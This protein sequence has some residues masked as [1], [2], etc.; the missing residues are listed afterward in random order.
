VTLPRLPLSLVVTIGLVALAGIML[1]RAVAGSRGELAVAEA[2]QEEGQ[3][4][5]AVEHYRRALRWSFPLS[6]FR[7]KAVT[8]L[9]SIAR[10]L[11]E[12][13]DRAGALLAW[14]SLAG[15]ITATRFIYSRSDPD[16]EQ[17][18]DEIA[19]LLALESDAAI[20]ANISMDKLTAAHRRL[21]AQQVSPHP[22]WGTILLF[23]FALWIGSV[24][25]LI[26]RGFSPRGEL[27]W[28]AARVPLSSALIGLVSFAAGLLF[29]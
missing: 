13:E 15:G 17:A 11:E 7:N 9:Q 16:A 12:A 10:Q 20:D 6:P 1:G 24:L 3:L 5:R 2:Y 23:G 14:R 4:L 18:K 19:R 21:L 8:G 25:L 28:P 22:L 29:A 26:N 27:L